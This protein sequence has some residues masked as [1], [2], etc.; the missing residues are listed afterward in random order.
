MGYATQRKGKLQCCV[1]LATVQHRN[2]IYTA[3]EIACM[4]RDLQHKTSE[5][6]SEK[7]NSKPI[8]WGLAHERKQRHR[9]GRTGKEKKDSR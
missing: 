1:T 7:K 3:T 6:S 9:E 4:L 5:Q 8:P 2:T